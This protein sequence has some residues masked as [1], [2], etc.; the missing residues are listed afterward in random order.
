MC[1]DQERALLPIEGNGQHNLT[2]QA[3]G[4]PGVVQNVGQTRFSTRQ[5][6]KP[7]RLWQ[8]RVPS[9]LVNAGCCKLAAIV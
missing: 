9:H 6:E 8:R 1:I 2:Q 3:S 5:S 7:N 4:N